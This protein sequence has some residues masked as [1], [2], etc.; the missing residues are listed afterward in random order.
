MKILITGGAGFIGSHFV[1][2][3]V[4]KYSE[5]VIINFDK[6]TYAGNLE[7]LKDIE[8]LPNYRF[9]KG[10]VCDL[11]FLCYLLKD[12]DLIF[13]FAAESHVDN[14]IG[15]SLNFTRTNTLGTHILLE[16]ARING[17]KKIFHI[18]TDEVY[19]DIVEGSFIENSI[20]NPTNPYSA[21]K[22][23]AEMVALGYLQTYKLPIV[24]V[25]GNNVYGSHQFTEKIIPKFISRLIKGEKVTIHGD[26]SN[27][28][29]YINVNDFCE[30]LHV[31]FEKGEV[32]E[33]YNIGTSDELTNL[34]LTKKILSLMNK[35]ESFIEFI[36]DRPFN[37]KRYSIDTNKIKKLGWTQ[38]ISFEKGLTETVKWYKENKSWWENLSQLS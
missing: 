19:G 5:H 8:N 6:L 26:G 9:V 27:I 17:V 10:D 34:E 1:R 7:R 15:D 24:I 33:V 20:L 21:S 3:M 2:H 14:S 12:V 38:K 28:R 23:A 35:D 32:G 13:H 37:D 36:R 11:N 29:T 22:A 18:S 31:I 16:A 4:K 30:A 25:R